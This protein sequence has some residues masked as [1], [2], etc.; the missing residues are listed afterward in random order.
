VASNPPL[1]R[2]D[3]PKTYRAI[4]SRYPPI[5][6][7]ER[8]ASA[9]EWD[10]LYEL[11]GM[12]NP[13]LRDEVGD[14]SL[15]PDEDRVYG[16]NASWVMG[17]FTHISDRK[18]SRFSDGSYGVYYAANT[19]LTAIKETAHHLGNT[20]AD[21]HAEAGETVRMRMLVGKVNELF[22]DIRGAA[23]PELHD[24]QDY[25]APQ[26][27]GRTVRSNGENGVVYDSVRDPGHGECLAAFRPK[28]VAIPVQG[29][30]YEYHWDGSHFDRYWRIGSRDSWERIWA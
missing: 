29:G 5:D 14:I 26:A 8:V 9:D 6:L 1:T 18:P 16:P 2:V 23:F 28:A 10:E 30:H 19:E 4:P 22:R 25:S 15:V 17:A 12:T 27:F 21:T 11:E 3:W 24:P 20:Y 7:F 13:R